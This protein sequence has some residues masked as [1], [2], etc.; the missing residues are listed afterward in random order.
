VSHRNLVKTESSTLCS[1]GELRSG[2][3]DHSHFMTKFSETGGGLEHLVD[4]PCIE[5]ILLENL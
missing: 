5:P 2:S 3:A 4:R 1:G